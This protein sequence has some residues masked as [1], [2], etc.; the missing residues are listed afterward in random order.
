ML[1]QCDIPATVDCIESPSCTDF[2]IQ[3]IGNINDSINARY[4]MCNFLW[5][6][7]IE[8]LTKENCNSV[9]PY[10]WITGCRMKAYKLSE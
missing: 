7:M 4:N 9:F 1:H 5:I 2:D 8:R 6:S 3:I 10:K